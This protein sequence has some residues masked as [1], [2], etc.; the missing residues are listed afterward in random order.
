MSDSKEQM[1]HQRLAPSRAARAKRGTRAAI[2]VLITTGLMAC[3][4]KI[5]L[6]PNADGVGTVADINDIDPTNDPDNPSVEDPPPGTIERPPGDTP[7]DEE[8]AC[9]FI[10]PG[11]TP[12]RRLTTHR[13]H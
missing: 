11:S 13:I 1:R 12:L 4:G 5:S 7:V 3:E 9:Q 2:L 8:P 6:N 10:D